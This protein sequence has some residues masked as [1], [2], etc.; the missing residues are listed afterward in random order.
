M[1]N[2]FFKNLLIAIAGAACTVPAVAEQVHVST[3]GTSLVLDATKGKKL[4]HVYYGAALDK[5][6]LGSITASGMTTND[7]Y[8]AYGMTILH[9]SAIAAVHPDG[10]MT[11]DLVVDKVSRKKVDGA[12]V[13]TI[14][15]KDTHYPF[16]VDV[17]YRSWPGD[18]V[19]ETWTEIENGEDGIVTLT[20]FASGHLPVRYGDV[21]MSQFF[22]T[23]HNE[24]HLDAAPIAH[25]EHVIKNTDGVR[26]S[27]T[28]H[29]EVML[30]LDGEPRE[31]DGRI[32]GAALCYSGNYKLRVSTDNSDYHHFFAGI[33]EENSE[34]HLKP[35]ERFVTPELA[36]TFSNEGL[37]GASRN[38]HRWGRNHRLQ[39]PDVP[40]KVLLNSWEG[41]YFDIK[42]NEMQQMMA[43]IADLGG[44]L[45]VMDD[46]WFGVKYPRDNNKSSLGDWTVDTDKLPHGIQGLCDAAKRNGIKFG[47]WIEPEM[48][49][50]YSELYEQHPEYVFKSPNREFIYGRGGTQLL[51]D[52]SNPAVQDLVFSVVDTLLTNYPD[53]DY[54]KWDANTTYASHGSQYL[55]ADDQSHLYIDYHRGLRS[56]WERIRAKYPDV[57]IQACAS[58]GGRANWGVLPWFEEFWVSDN[59]DA[60]QRVFLQWTASYFF[61]PITMASHISAAPNHQTFRTIP[62]KYRIDVAMSGRLGM[63]MQPSAMTDDEK[64]MCKRAI[65]QYKTYVR[66]VLQDGDIYRLISPYEGKQVASLMYVTPDKNKSVFY[67]WKTETFRKQQLPAVRMAGLDPDKLYKI[68]EL[69]AV[70]TKPLKFEGKTFTGKFLMENGLEI[71]FEHQLNAADRNAFS[72][73]VLLLEAQK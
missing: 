6:D 23:H 32:I 72:S 15:L 50:L 9:P 53:I 71:P 16:T 41:V 70:D 24:A 44:E 61:P 60:L 11:L 55:T 59:T 38:F 52:L 58:G 3:P 7:A 35:G 68:T 17:N 65:E 36:L 51:L 40:R 43:D 56:V 69:N 37:S 73:R 13:V 18:D 34:Y 19:I 46:G 57:T 12:D 8:P 27:Q 30:S 42:E 5:R 29:A 49:N 54:I 22:G 26:N 64:A 63:E 48:T 1:N 10:N 4:K 21:W 45:F 2:N 39:H 66:P 33:D 62:M 47:I 14:T 25:G 31:N 20:Q 28:S 67:W